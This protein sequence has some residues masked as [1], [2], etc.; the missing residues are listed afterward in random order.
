MVVTA[1][2]RKIVYVT[3]DLF[4]GGG[5][6]GMLVRMV[7]ADE[8]L[9]DEITV[10]SLLPGGEAHASRLR[11]AGVSVIELDFRAAGGICSGLLRLARLIWE[12][13]PDIVQGWMYHG[14]L[15]ALVALV[16]S[17]RRRRT[18]LVWS[19]RCSDMDLRRYGIGL[20]MVVKACTLLSR[21]PDV[22]TANSTNGLQAHLR[23]GYRPRKAEVIAN[24]IDVDQFRPDVAARAAVRQELGIP[25]DAT[26]VAHLARVDLMKDHEG[27]LAAMAQLPHLRA[28]LIGS[29]TE[30]LPEQSN[31]LRLGR[32]QD[33]AR[34]L[35]AADFI[36]S[37]SRFGEGFSNAIA[38]GM[39]CGL[40]AIS[41]EVGDARII[42]GDAGIIVPPGNPNALAAA[43]RTLAD[44]PVSERARR[45]AGARA[46][47]VEN[48]S[49]ALAVRRHA[50]LYASLV[51]PRKDSTPHSRRRHQISHQPTS[52]LPCAC[53]TSDEVGLLSLIGKLRSVSAP[54]R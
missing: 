19:I 10:V 43:I 9:A 31:A 51:A 35:A 32:R 52:R 3:T 17:G 1:R 27:F 2:P 13:Q 20:R 5:A 8:R 12:I 30:T 49:M 48:F 34:L 47:I 50:E 45:G 53:M 41:T 29:R 22:I 44:E 26:V 7:T 21:S 54:R 33:V 24:G 4:V 6:E 46:R 38:E 37:S 15:A 28:V 25:S 11:A 23:L 14:D 39:A 42:V 40:P 18:H 16:L 36:V